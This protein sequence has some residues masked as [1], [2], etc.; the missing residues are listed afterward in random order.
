[1]SWA[2]REQED[3]DVI[4]FY[5]DDK[6]KIVGASGWGLTSRITKDLKIARVLVERG[7]VAAGDVLSNPETKLKSLL[8]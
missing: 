8:K 1:L 3:G 2:V 7:V 4:I 6:N 5:L